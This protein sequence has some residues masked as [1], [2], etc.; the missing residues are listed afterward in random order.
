MFFSMSRRPHR[1]D[2]PPDPGEIL[3][4][5]RACRKVMIEISCK[6]KIN[7]PVYLAADGVMNAID[8]LAAELTGDREFFWNKPAP[9]KSVERNDD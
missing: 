3:D 2:L 8:G 1:F 5:L 9:S 4:T 6:V 7:G